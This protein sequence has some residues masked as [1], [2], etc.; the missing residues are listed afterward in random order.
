MSHAAGES[1]AIEFTFN[2]ALPSLKMVN[3]LFWPR[4]SIA[5][6]KLTRGLVID[7]F[8]SVTGSPVVTS[9]WRTSVGVRKR[10]IVAR[11]AD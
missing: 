10:P 9:F 11:A 7:A 1:G 8:G 5:C 2:V 6:P 3:E 4:V